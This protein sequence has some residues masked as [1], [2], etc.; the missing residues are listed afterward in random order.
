MTDPAPDPTPDPT[1]DTGTPADPETPP[2]DPAMGEPSADEIKAMLDELGL[3]PGQVKGRL[4]ASKKWEQRAKRADEA[5]EAARQASLGDL[6]RAQEAANLATERALAAERKAVALEHGLPAELAER[7]VGS[8][9]EELAEDAARLKGLVAPQPTTPQPPAGSA[10]GGPQ[11]TP[12]PTPGLREQIAA[13]EAAGDFK[14]S[15]A[16][17]GQ[18]LAETAGVTV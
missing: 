2:A 1:P 13:A 4:E 18:L 3:T 7:L 9:P 10:D 11:G 14:T 5:E 16:L 17:K 6:Q 15:L 12:A 8:T